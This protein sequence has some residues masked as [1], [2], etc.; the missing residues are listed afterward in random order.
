MQTRGG[1]N[2]ANALTTAS[3][4]GTRTFLVTKLGTDSIGDQIAAE[5]EQ[6]GVSTE[7]VLRKEGLSSF[8]YM[9]VDKQ[10][11]QQP[12]S[13]VGQGGLH[14]KHTQQTVCATA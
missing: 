9:I 3:R 14:L 1:G 10:G 8:G 11:E 7:F 6:D 13:L 2:C 5:L 4:L 12:C